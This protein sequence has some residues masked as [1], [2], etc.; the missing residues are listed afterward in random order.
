MFIR[1][2]RSRSNTLAYFLD[3]FIKQ[4]RSSEHVDSFGGGVYAAR[5]RGFSEVIL[6]ERVNV[7]H[8]QMI[9]DTSPS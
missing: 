3:D 5:E 4:T 1:E 7:M 9:R 8:L 6:D 2:L